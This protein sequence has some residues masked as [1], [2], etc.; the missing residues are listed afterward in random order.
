M[1][2]RDRKANLNSQERLTLSLLSSL[3]CGL[4]GLDSLG[5]GCD[6]GGLGEV[7]MLDQRLGNRGNDGLGNG[8]RLD[9]GLGHLWGCG[10]A[11]ADVL[12]G[13]GA[14][15]ANV[16]LHQAGGLGSTLAS[17]ILQL[18]GLGID[19]LLEVADLL[20]ND[21]AVADVDQRGE[22][23]G[24]DGDHSEAPEGNEADQ[25]VTGKS[26]SESLYPSVSGFKSDWLLVVSTYCNGVDNILGEQNALELN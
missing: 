18:V 15:L 4:N 12:L 25:P 9:G 5:H 14:V 21:L 24:G 23:S 20:I 26:S 7:L 17:Q 6:L 1:T 10:A 19:N 16:L 13:L 22:V 11:G 3:L 2:W 8:L